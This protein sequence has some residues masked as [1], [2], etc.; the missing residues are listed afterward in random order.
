MSHS[1]RG[2]IGLAAGI[3]VAAY[4][5][6]SLAGDG[7]DPVR[8]AVVAVL[9]ASVCWFAVDLVAE[10]ET[11]TTGT[12]D[13]PAAGP[14]R[15]FDARTSRL[16]RRL[17][18]IG[19]PGFDESPLYRELVELADERLV[20]RRDVDRDAEPDRARRIMGPRLAEFV[21]RKPPDRQFA[22]RAYLEQIVRE[23][24]EL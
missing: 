6:L 20:R 22:R 18:E 10:V 3:T 13:A 24:E 8:A 21:D 1:W 16:S 5:V 19:R 11:R 14:R 9:C 17:G 23:I 4:V 7:L 15:G 12:A 2:R